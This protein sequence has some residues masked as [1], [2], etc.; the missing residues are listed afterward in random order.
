VTPPPDDNHPA[1]IAVQCLFVRHRNALLV[2]A[3]FE[4]LYVDHYLHLMQHG[5]RIDP[6]LDLMLKDTLAAMTLHLA[7]RPRNEVSAWTLH[8]Q[9]P[10]VNL[11]A[12]GDSRL[13]NVIGR[14]FTEN[15]R[16]SGTSLL[17]A[18]TNESPNPARR[19][20]VEFEGT[21][22]FPIIEDFYRQSEQRRAR[23][24]DLGEESYA[25]ISAQPECD[26]A[27]LE[28]L[29]EDAVRVLDATEELGLLENRAYHYDCGCSMDRVIPAL[30]PLGPTDLDEIFQEDAALKVTCPRCAA[31][32]LV[33]RQDIER[34]RRAP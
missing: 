20:I 31:I 25:L 28:S 7:S 23:L 9:D 32:F 12:T 3:A 6:R 16:D 30:A 29:D 10:L 22:I 21:E 14:V 17:L 15:V 18:Q 19:S 24:F 27:W 33:T 1:D 5:I 4:P 8:F 13:G 26:L 11:F 2:R 34:F